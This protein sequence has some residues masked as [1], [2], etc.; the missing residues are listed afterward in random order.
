MATMKVTLEN[1]QLWLETRGK[2]DLGC[3]VYE[4]QNGFLQR[5]HQNP[6]LTVAE[7]R[8]GWTIHVNGGGVVAAVEVTTDAWITACR[9]FSLQP[10]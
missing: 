8:N 3:A 9:T 4:Q 6:A 2:G 7:S 1:H 10:R 5:V